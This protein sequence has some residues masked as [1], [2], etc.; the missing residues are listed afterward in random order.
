MDA[1]FPTHVILRS[2]V[3]VPRAEAGAPMSVLA[4]ESV[5][6]GLAGLEWASGLPGTVGGAIV[7]NA[8]AFD[9]DIASVL[10]TTS[11]LGR[12]GTV[13]ERKARWFR[14]E[15]RGSRI[16]DM[17]TQKR[18]VVLEA[19]FALSEG[20]ADS[21]AKRAEEILEW[22]RT[23]HPSGATLGSTFRN[24]DESHAGYLIEQAGLRG[25][26]VG[27]A[28]VS[29]LHGNFFINMGGAS[30]T[31]VLALANHVWAEVR[32]KSGED[33]QLEIELP[34]ADAVVGDAAGVFVA[35]R[36]Q[37]LRGETHRF[38]III[39]ID[40]SLSTSQPTGVDMRAA[41]PLPMLLI[42]PSST[43]SAPKAAT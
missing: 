25:Y 4:R 40:T 43:E 36:A 15:Y 12:D 18:P 9:G 22:R 39:V 37:A 11:V 21:L 28:R 23:R 7:G 31:D 27:G 30:A 26:R 8:G 16:K 1:E 5:G 34:P 3:R 33:L 10:K 6:R 2:L 42:V 20:D 24:P 38:D 29:E 14:L 35:G 19:T 41:I 32:R 13:T 17:A